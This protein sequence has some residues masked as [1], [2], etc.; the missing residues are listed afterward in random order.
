MTVH[1]Y[2]ENMRPDEEFVEGDYCYLVAGNK[3]RLL[4]GRRTTGV[5]EEYF[6]ESGMFKWRITKYEDEGKCWKLPA[7]DIKRFQ[8]E[9]DS[10]K[11][12]PKSISDIRAAV[13]KY[14]SKI[15]IEASNEDREKTQNIIAE[16]KGQAKDWLQENS[17]FL[18]ENDDIDFTRK[19]GYESLYQDIK[20][21]MKD[22]NL[23]EQEDLTT[24]SFVL[25]PAS[26]E[27]VKGLKI[28]LAELGLVT[29]KGKKI[30]TDDIFKGAGNKLMRRK[31]II[32]RLAFLQA[33]FELLAIEEVILYRG[34]STEKG[35]IEKD[36][37]FLSCTFNREVAEAF[38]CMERDSKYKNSYI[39]KMTYPIDK[40]FLTF[41][42]TAEMNNQY[43]EAEAIVLYSE[44][45]K[46]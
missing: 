7:E 26:G 11:L 3:C 42:E 31:Y 4:D 29:Y 39:V 1:E 17:K 10:K 24:N 25:N 22:H 21:Y 46:I 33:L 6:E 15:T 27:W 12:G 16:T 23:L 14:N 28:M 5:I 2:D 38:C 19:E 41:F 20:N 8:F 9:K 40:L 13:R 18:K 34:M 43:Q 35:W 45:I 44:E 30:R 36:R 37:T 32:N